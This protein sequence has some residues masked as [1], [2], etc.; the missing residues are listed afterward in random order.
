MAK[1]GVGLAVARTVAALRKQVG[2]WRR[3]GLSV[4]L[5]PTMGALHAG[6]LELVRQALKRADRVIVSLFVNPTQFGPNEDYSRY[7]RDEAGDAAKLAGVGAHLL[8]APNTSEMYP[9]GF[10]TSVS[11]GALAEPLEGQFRPG[12]FA[13]VATV[14]TKLLNQAQA[15]F[16]C[17]GEKDYQQLRVIARLARDLDIATEIVPV[18][19]MRERD[20]LAL[21]SRNA[22]LTPEERRIA[23]ALHR[24]LVEVGERVRQGAPIV[25]AIGWGLFELNLA[26]FGSVDYLAITDAMT[27]KPLETL[28]RP[29]RILVA[30]RLGRTRLI[31]NESL[32]PAP[33]PKAR[34]AAKPKAKAKRR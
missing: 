17:F 19:T 1:P 34:P 2:E 24:I 20:G 26:G 5:V 11:I 23:P 30:A 21:S 31:D 13:G 9:D 8:Y 33:K 3:R 18:K 4:A 22:Y 29:A 16:A 32:A 27:L 6:H 28:D 12:H 7:P 14:V 25:Q 10:A 15:D